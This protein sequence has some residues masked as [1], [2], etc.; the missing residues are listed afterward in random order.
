LDTLAGNFVARATA[1]QASFGFD[2]SIGTGETGDRR[3]ALSAPMRK[4]I[5]PTQTGGHVS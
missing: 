2:R 3:Q 4:R 5:A 1:E